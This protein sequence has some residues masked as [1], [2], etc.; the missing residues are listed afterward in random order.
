MYVTAE[1]PLRVTGLAGGGASLQLGTYPN[2]QIKPSVWMAL[3]LHSNCSKVFSVQD[4]SYVLKL[5]DRE[6]VRVNVQIRKW[7]GPLN[8]L[9][10][11][12]NN[13]VNSDGN[14]RLIAVI[15][16]HGHGRSIKTKWKYWVYLSF[17]NK[18]IIL[19]NMMNLHIVNCLEWDQLRLSRFLMNRRCLIVFGT[20]PFWLS[21]LW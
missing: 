12:S 14:E 6:V 2:P 17:I 21:P 19:N 4:T 13:L 3:A 5:G 16:R 11:S 1:L 7:K 18:N 15:L 10:S 8:C 9:I 20:S